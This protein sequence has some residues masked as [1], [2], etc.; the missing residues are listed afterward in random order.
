[1][2]KKTP[3]DSFR[4]FSFSS[5]KNEKTVKITYRP[6]KKMHKKSQHEIKAI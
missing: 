5:R 6:I 2:Y 3:N 1:M 4:Y